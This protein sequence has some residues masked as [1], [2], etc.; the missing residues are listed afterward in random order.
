VKCLARFS[1]L[2][3]FLAMVVG[4]GPQSVPVEQP[5][6]AQQE[7]VVR[8]LEMVAESGQLGSEMMEIQQSLE[9]MKATDSETAT[10]LL[11]DLEEMES[12]TDPAGVK[13]KA[14]E[15]LDKLGSG[16]SEPAESSQ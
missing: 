4:C 9:E 10:E 13:A 3:I 2:P 6:Q 14:N 1:F 15:M 16:S 11:A 7:A 8:N 12:M 5:S